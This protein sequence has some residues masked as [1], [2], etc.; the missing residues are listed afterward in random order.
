MSTLQD[1]IAEVSEGLKRGW[2][3][4]LARYCGVKPPSVADWVSG[5]TLKL[6]GDNLLRAAEFFGV[7]PRW[8]SSGKGPKPASSDDPDVVPIAEARARRVRGAEIDIDHYATGGSMGTGLVLRDQ[9]GVI[10]RWTVT[11]EWVQKNLNNVTSPHNLAI[12]T[13]FGNSMRPMFNPGDP[14]LV[15]RGVTVCEFDGLYFFRV[16]NEGFI[17]QLQRIPT[18]NGIIIRAKSLNPTF[19]PFDITKGMDFEVFARVVK[20]WKGEDV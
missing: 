5:K 9:P 16:G 4:D 2:Q 1:R 6:D 14:I 12:V 15:D 3:A 19:D 7:R 11:N 20:T 8:L 17:K 10:R 18:D 13:G